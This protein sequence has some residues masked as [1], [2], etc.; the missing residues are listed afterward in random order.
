MLNI[1]RRASAVYIAAKRTKPQLMYCR[2]A[3]YPIWVDVCKQRK[4]ATRTHQ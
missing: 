1:G 2:N 3:S 4:W